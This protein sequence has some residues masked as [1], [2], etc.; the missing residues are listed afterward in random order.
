[1]KENNGQAGTEIEITPEMIE[2]GADEFAKFSEEGETRHFLRRLAL[3]V[4]QA[5]VSTQQ[6]QVSQR[7]DKVYP[8]E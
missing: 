6:R 7:V 5:M 4:F 3:D 1:M 2:A 8:S